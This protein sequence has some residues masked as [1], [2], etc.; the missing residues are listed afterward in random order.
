MPKPCAVTIN[1]AGELNMDR[2]ITLESRLVIGRLS[3]PPRQ[4][5]ISPMSDPLDDHQL[6]HDLVV[7][8][9]GAQHAD[10]ARALA[11]DGGGTV[12]I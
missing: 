9:D 10:L 8:A 7:R 4:K 3:T 1:S 11:T 6:G 5:L 2:L 12:Q